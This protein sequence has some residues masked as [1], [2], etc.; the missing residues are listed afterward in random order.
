[1]V[2]N[3]IPKHDIVFK[4]TKNPIVITHTHRINWIS[5]IYSLEMQT[6]MV[7]ILPP[8]LISLLY[9]SLHIAREAVIKF[10]EFWSYL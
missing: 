3:P 8:Q 5:V 1:M 2:A 9:L 4:K 7:G 6:R 10:P